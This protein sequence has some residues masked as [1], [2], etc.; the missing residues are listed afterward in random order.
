M[1]LHEKGKT[2]AMENVGG[3]QTHWPASHVARPDGRHLVSYR[4]DQVGGAP[5]CPYEYPIPVKVDTH[6][7]FWGFHLQSSLS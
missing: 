5:P 7:T 3:G 1:C 2:M 4:L 6:I